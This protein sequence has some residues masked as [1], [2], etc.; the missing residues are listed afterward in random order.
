MD[1]VKIL[2]IL[3]VFLGCGGDEPVEEPVIE[4]PQEAP[5]FDPSP[6]AIAFASIHDGDVDVDPLPLNRDGIVIRFDEN[7]SKFM[8]DLR[9][10]GNVDIGSVVQHAL[11]PSPQGES[12]GWC[13]RLN[14][15]NT[16][17]LMPPPPLGRRFLEYDT[18]YVLEFIVQDGGRYCLASEIVFQTKAR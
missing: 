13:R 18:V 15:A 1:I 17:T 11:Q 6:P 9:S 5:H 2:M 4:R 10:L 16:L 12:L 8:I 7:I 3:L 14:P